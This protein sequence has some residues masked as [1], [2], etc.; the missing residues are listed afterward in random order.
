MNS[1]KFDI[2]VVGGG[3]AGF[4]SAIN[5]AEKNPKLSVA[6]LER[7]VELLG[8]VKISGGGRCN[9][10]HACFDPNELVKYY[11]RGE[12]ELR[13]PFQQFNPTHIIEWFKNHGVNLKTEADGRMFP[14]SNTSQ[15][16]IDC[17]L[18]YA[19]KLRIQILTQ[20]SVQNIQKTETEWQLST[21]N[22]K[23]N[24]EKLVIT[25]GSNPKMWEMMQS[26]GHKIIEPVPSLFTFS[27]EKK[28]SITQLSGISCMVSLQVIQTKLQTEGNLLITHKGFSGP[29]VLKL[30]AWGAPILAQKNYQFQ[31]KI[32]WL[33]NEVNLNQAIENLQ[34]IKNNLLKKNI[35][36]QPQFKFPQRLWDYLLQTAQINPEKKWADISK[37]ETQLLAETLTQNTHNITSKNTFKEEFVTAGGIDLKEINFKTMQSKIH[38]TL[39]FAGETLNIDAVTGGFNFQNA[40]TTGYILSQNIS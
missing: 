18:H 29:A 34:K 9:V 25:T 12:K 23:F 2:I 8:K 7:G 38:D 15:T 6:I 5:I 19:Q 36:T 14:V 30:S 20:Q 21:P 11:P 1:Q 16:I 3:A 4:F 37:K 10:T 24:C 31:L 35:G 39:Y 40:W 28:N 17:F 22:Q 26:L 13:G 33:T 27:V 32:N